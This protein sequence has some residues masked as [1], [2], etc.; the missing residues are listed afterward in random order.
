MTNGC[1][2]MSYLSPLASLR[3]D[4]RQQRRSVFSQVYGARWALAFWL[5]R[6]ILGQGLSAG[7]AALSAPVP[8]VRTA[9]A[10]SACAPN[11]GSRTSF[12]ANGA[13]R[14]CGVTTSKAW[15]Q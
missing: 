10:R 7:K 9:L 14:Y 13:R 11:D 5:G 6:A 1:G 8:S 2:G 12:G 15:L 4:R 3:F